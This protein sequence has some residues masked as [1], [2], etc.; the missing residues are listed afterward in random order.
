[1]TTNR[2]II[3]RALRKLGAVA[4]GAEPSAARADAGLDLLLGMYQEWVQLGVFG[5]LNDYRTSVDI[6]ALPGQRIYADTGLTI[7]L[8]TPYSPPYNDSNTVGGWIWDYGWPR[9]NGQNPLVNQ[10][11]ISVI[12]D[13]VERLYVYNNGAWVDFNTQDLNSNFPLSAGLENGTAAMLALRLAPE[14]GN[15]PSALV[16]REAQ[17]AQVALTHRYNNPR[18]VE[19]LYSL[20]Y[21]YGPYG[22]YY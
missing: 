14:Y 3:K 9:W 5:R 16:L 20:G 1:M 8:P 12:Q 2:D 15:D 10:S 17:Q 11:L 22:A 4:A 7:S 19:P 18:T 6:T 21:P 13:G